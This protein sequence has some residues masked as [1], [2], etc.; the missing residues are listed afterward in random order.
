M[1]WPQFPDASRQVRDLRLLLGE[2]TLPA[3]GVLLQTFQQLATFLER[4]EVFQGLDLCPLGFCEPRLRQVRDR[5]R[6]RIWRSADEDQVLLGRY[7]PGA[8]QDLE[9]G[10]R[11]DCELIGVEQTASR[12]GHNEVGHDVPEKNHTLRQ[13]FALQLDDFLFLF[14]LLFLHLFLGILVL[15]AALLVLFLRRLF[16]HLLDLLR[17]LRLPQGDARHSPAD[18]ANEGIQR[19]LVE[20][21]H[22]AQVAQ[23]EKQQGASA[24]DGSV[25]FRRLVDLSLSLLCEHDFLLHLVRRLLR[26]FQTEDQLGVVEDV[27]FGVREFFQQQGL[28]L[29]QRHLELVLLLNELRLLLR[30]VGAFQLDDQEQQLVL[31]AVLGDGEVDDRGL[32]LNLGRVV[33][34]GQ[35]RLHVQGE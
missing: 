23:Q 21:V 8:E 10:H 16:L 3:Q 25:E 33:G 13:L 28:Q 12:V 27:A 29:G 17:L 1:V 26:L 35:L 18:D 20:R 14:L 6:V 32:G 31:Q 15:V 34:V 30:E 9:Q 22:L 24:T 7:L 19:V 11:H 4:L 5:R 2:P